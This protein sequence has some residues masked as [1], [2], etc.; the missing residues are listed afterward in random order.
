MAEVYREADKEVSENSRKLA[1]L[2]ALVR[3]KDLL[4]EQLEVRLAASA[5]SAQLML[6][7]AEAASKRVGLADQALAES[8]MS[9]KVELAGFLEK[10]AEARSGNLLFCAI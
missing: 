8:R 10:L 4:L 1:K 7:E 3:E 6:Q 9:H 5:R 2:E